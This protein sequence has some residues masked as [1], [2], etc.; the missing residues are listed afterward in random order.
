V[1]QIAVICAALVLAATPV[2]AQADEVDVVATEEDLIEASAGRFGGG[3]VGGGAQLGRGSQA[4]GSDRDLVRVRDVAFGTGEDGAR[5]IRVVSV[6]VDADSAPPEDQENPRILRMA[7]RYPLCPDSEALPARPAPSALADAFWQDQVPLP[8]PQPSV[9][10]ADGITGIP[11]YLQIA[12][13]QEGTWSFETFGITITISATSTYDI[14]WGD[15]T[16]VTGITSQGG[17]YP[18][19]DI[20]HGYRWK[21]TYDIVVTQQWTATWTASG[22]GTAGGGTITGVLQTVG[23]VEDFVVTEVQAVR[24][25]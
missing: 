22:A 15:G 17:P 5:C 25:R 9:Q 2:M 20:V 10:P 7:D 16:V 12:G 18:D 14:D 4:G 6:W 11:V 1:R 19:G 3:P 23:I 24:E 8:K 13:P 21:G